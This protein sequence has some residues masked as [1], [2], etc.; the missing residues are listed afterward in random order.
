MFFLSSYDSR[1]TIIERIGL[2]LKK[3]NQNVLIYQYT[4]DDNIIETQKDSFIKFI[5]TH[6]PFEKTSQYLKETKIVLDIHKEIQH[7]LSFRVFEAMGLGK[8]LIT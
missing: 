2:Q 6:I 7:G 1:F 4:I 8:K 5:N 3:Q